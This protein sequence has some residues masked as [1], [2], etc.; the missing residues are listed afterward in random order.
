MKD[1]YKLAIDAYDLLV[2]EKTLG[3]VNVPVGQKVTAP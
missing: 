2:K 3:R 1:A